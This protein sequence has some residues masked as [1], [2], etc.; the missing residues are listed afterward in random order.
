MLILNSAMWRNDSHTSE[1]ITDNKLDALLDFLVSHFPSVRLG[2]G[3]IFCL[4]LCLFL[5]VI[6]L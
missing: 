1:L 5:Y 2:K 4:F 3:S 6:E